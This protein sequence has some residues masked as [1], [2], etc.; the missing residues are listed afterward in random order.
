MKLLVKAVD[1]A[2]H[3]VREALTSVVDKLSQSLEAA[4]KAATA[5]RGAGGS[6]AAVVFVATQMRVAVTLNVGDSRAVAAPVDSMLNGQQMHDPSMT[7]PLSNDHDPCTNPSELGR[8]LQLD[9]ESS[10]VLHAAISRSLWAPAELKSYMWHNL[11]DRHNSSVE[12]T[13][14]QRVTVDIEGWTVVT[15]QRL[16]QSTHFNSTVCVTMEFAPLASPEATVATP[17]VGR[18][19]P[20]CDGGLR[21]SRAFGDFVLKQRVPNIVPAFEVSVIPL[22]KSSSVIVVA[23]DGLWEHIKTEQV[24]EQVT[25]EFRRAILQGSNFT[26][27]M[28][29]LQCNRLAAQAAN[30]WRLSEGSGERDDIAIGLVFLPHQ[31]RQDQHLQQTCLKAPDWFDLVES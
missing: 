5:K 9:L 11:T 26:S 28:A 7:L 10:R 8:I 20:R 19:A 22:P 16:V 1:C 13:I 15:L 25:A 3:G 21:M 6:T 24:V 4:A 29:M 12:C 14:R 31:S 30:A 17:C 18:V 23:S 27:A 2:S